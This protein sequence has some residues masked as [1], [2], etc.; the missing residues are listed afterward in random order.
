M[1]G[2]GSIERWN[3]GEGISETDLELG[4]SLVA[5]RFVDEFM[6]SAAGSPQTYRD[7]AY[8]DEL[9]PYR[10]ALMPLANTADMNVAIHAGAVMAI[11]GG[12]QE[13]SSAAIEPEQLLSYTPELSVTIAAADATLFRRDLIQ[14][15]IVATDEALVTRHFEDAVTGAKTTQTFV[16]RAN[17]VVEVGVKS[18][19]TFASGVLA[20]ALTAEPAPDAGWFRLASIQ[21]PPAVTALDQR[22]MWDWRMPMGFGGATQMPQNMA[23]EDIVCWSIKNFAFQQLIANC[24]ARIHALHTD[25]QLGSAA[26]GGFYRFDQRR[27]ANMILASRLNPTLDYANIGAADVNSAGFTTTFGALLRVPG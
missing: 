18:S 9:R 25:R 3:D 26:D 15:R 19:A 23:A 1:P 6:F 21:V 27:V 16:K 8:R 22:N 11:V 20:D 17:A 2:F 13:L 5:R 7:R 4:P 14:A 10:N 24:Q 12:A